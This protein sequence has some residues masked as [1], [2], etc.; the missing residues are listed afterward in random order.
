[1]NK[2]IGALIALFLSFTLI[3]CQTISSS[4]QN[5][6]GSTISSGSQNPIDPIEAQALYNRMLLDYHKKIISKEKNLGTE[7]Y[8][9]GKY[10]TDLSN[11]S[12]N[13]LKLNFIYSKTPNGAY[14][15][16]ILNSFYTWGDMFYYAFNGKSYCTPMPAPMVWF[17]GEIHY[18]TDAYY[19]GII[20]EK[21]VCDTLSDF[22][23]ESIFYTRKKLLVTESENVKYDD[24]IE[25]L[26]VKKSFLTENSI[27]EKIKKDFIDS[28]VV[29]N[30]ELS[31]YEILEEDIHVFQSF[32]KVGDAVCVNYSIDGITPPRYVCNVVEKKWETD[33]EIDGTVIKK[34]QE[35]MPVVWVKSC[36]Y[37]IDEA[38]S[39]GVINKTTT[40]ELLRQYEISAR[41]NNYDSY[42]SY[43]N[44][45][46][47][48]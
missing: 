44:G 7:M 35:K 20:D 27:F 21:I 36:F 42:N 18:I 28:F 22:T 29:G 31:S 41:Q 16:G 25:P 34:F 40:L 14:I 32:A 11:R 45:T 13:D 15:V 9:L 19:L 4:S 5:S 24:S 30:E 17:E 47:N 26:E 43:I 48:N 8:A 10:P 39:S 37:P 38:Y 46:A 3:G 2:K 23:N 1:M 6:E 33:F 12:V